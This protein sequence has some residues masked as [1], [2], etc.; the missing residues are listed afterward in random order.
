[1][2]V[3]IAGV[4]EEDI[5]FPQQCSL[6]FIRN[7]ANLKE[8]GVRLYF[9]TQNGKLGRLVFTAEEVDLFS[10]MMR[11]KLAENRITLT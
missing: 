5:Q 10:R 7:P 6:Q 2:H 3:G 4:A 1:M 8:S 9:K 11:D